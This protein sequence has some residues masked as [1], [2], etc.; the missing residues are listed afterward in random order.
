MS[1][2]QPYRTR[3]EVEA[4]KK[5]DPIARFETELIERGVLTEEQVR[6]IEDEAQGDVAEAVEYAK[7]APEPALER[8]YDGVYV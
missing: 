2:A 1:D 6:Q 4:W 5:K 3:E 8:L 7:T